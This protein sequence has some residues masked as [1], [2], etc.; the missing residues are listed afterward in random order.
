MVGKKCQTQVDVTD[1]DPHPAKKKNKCIFVDG[2]KT[3]R[4]FLLFTVAD[5]E[6]A[7]I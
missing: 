2:P 1:R 7:N 6:S 5:V 4:D 3:V